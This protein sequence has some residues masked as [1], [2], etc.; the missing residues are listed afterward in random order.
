MPRINFTVNIRA[1]GI[2]APL[3]RAYVEHIAFGLRVP[4]S[5]LYMTDENGNVRDGAGN[6]GIDAM[7][8][9]LNGRID[10]RVICHNSV[11]KIPNGI[12]DHYTDFSVMDG[13]TVTLNSTNSAGNL[14]NFR[15]L[16]RA[17]EVHDKV[18]RQFQVFNS[19]FP[20][21]RKRS[22]DDTRKSRK[23]IEVFFPSA[24][25][26]KLA[27]VEPK[28]IHTGYPIIH[29]GSNDGSAPL[30][31]PNNRLFGDDPKLVPAELSH[32]LHFSYLTE[33][34]RHDI[35]VR[36][37]GFIVS[38]WV[39]GG[40]GT[41]SMLKDTDPMVAFLEAFDHFVHRF[42]RFI[43]A[44]PTLTGVP[45]RNGFILAELNST[46]Q[47]ALNGTAVTGFG[48]LNGALRRGAF[49]PNPQ[50]VSGGARSATSIEGSVYGAIFLDFARRPGVGL[51]TV[52][53]AFVRSKAL[54]FGE[55]RTWI[56]SNAPSLLPALNQV[57]QAWGL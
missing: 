37:G 13:G 21:G 15:I 27:F 57:S 14:N 30:N 54:T 45:L 9:P 47:F 12:F 22:L 56:Q 28:S 38:D 34:Q 39:L 40:G 52:V 29:I 11:V 36:Y 53:N 7:P 25:V 6:L 51:R 31:S 26:V 42:D 41:H 16:N 48:T 43:T 20:L 10:I 49:T 46:E 17:F 23:R 24:L 8:N 5:A 44:N 35:A 33:Q 18:L 3:K 4:G 1:G 19:D 32:A 55:F 2:T 50:F